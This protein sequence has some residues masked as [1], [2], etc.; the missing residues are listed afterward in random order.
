MVLS[1]SQ[2]EETCSLARRLNNWSSDML[3]VELRDGFWGTTIAVGKLRWGGAPAT[4]VLAEIRLSHL[5]TYGLILGT[6][7]CQL[8][9]V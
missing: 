5:I 6:I 3:M 9:C 1:A 8:V 2:M 4:Q 7:C